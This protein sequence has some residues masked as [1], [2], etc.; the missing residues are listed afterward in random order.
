MSV[1]S[2]VSHASILLVL[3]LTTVVYA[4]GCGKDRMEEDSRGNR[5][6]SGL[7]RFVVLDPGHFHAALVFKRPGYEG[8]SQEVGIYAPVGEDFTDHMAR[9]I[10]FNNRDDNPAVW[11]YRVYL[12]LDFMEAMLGEKFGDVVIISGRNNRKIDCILEGIE[13]GFNF[14]ADKPL[15]I[16]PE[17]FALL[18]S[19][20]STADDK[21]LVAIDI[22]TERY[23]IT[24][25]LQRLIVR[26]EPV[27]GTLT[28]GSPENPA[29]V[30]SSVHHL[31]K[32]VA[33]R[34][35]KRPWWFFDTSIQGEGLV[36]ITTHL[37]DLVFWIL[38]P[39]QAIDYRKD[40]DMVS[41][42]H[43]PTVLSAEQFEKITGKT[44]FPPHL[45]LDDKGNL[46]YYC[47]GKINFRLKGVNVQ[48]EVIWNFQ[49]PE[50]TG[51]AHYSVMNGTR[52][53]VLVLQGEEQ[54]F[55]PE[56]YIKSAPGIDHAE[57]GNALKTFITSLAD[58]EYPGLSL[59]E[60]KD[61]WR[62]NIP[63]KYR[64][65]HEAHFGQV[66]DRFL[67][68]L[69]GEPIPEWE[70]INLMS[71]YYVTTKALELCRREK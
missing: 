26:H 50:G 55:L 32:Y 58:G 49:A 67:E 30:K 47:N 52:A 43:W 60:E 63:E 33:G 40:I 10:P 17:K 6:E 57:L 70:K 38:Y 45:S 46:P 3:G 48:V 35:L 21:G 19:V 65:G 29:V 42:S 16:D 66:T 5:G 25:I 71:K 18:D 62:I 23:E 68:Y 4:G 37:V 53:H 15:V 20:L 27:F 69:N 14:L 31:F 24:S 51:D 39:E 54:N 64:V 11:S 12:G 36:D 7:H 41:A 56:V 2:V 8:I 61:R 9:V 44:E 28:G 34:P 22:M 1:L 13:A 59:V